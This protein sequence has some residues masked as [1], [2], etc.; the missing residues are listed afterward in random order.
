MQNKRCAV[1]EKEEF[2]V[3]DHD[4]ETGEVRGLLCRGCNKKLSK[5]DA[6]IKDGSIYKLLKYLKI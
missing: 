6:F 2:L 5:I 1:C 3:I 4:H